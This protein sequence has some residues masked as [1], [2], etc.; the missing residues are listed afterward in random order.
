VFKIISMTAAAD[1]GIFGLNQ[2]YRCTGTWQQPDGFTRYDW[3]EGG[4]GTITL[5]QSLTYSCD[6]YNY[7]IGLELNQYD[8]EALGNYA[9]KLGLGELTGVEELD[10]A[11]GH[12]PD[13]D[14]V[15]NNTTREWTY[16]D[17]INMAVGQG[18]V[19][20]TPLQV[21]RMMAAVANGGTLY[22]P[23]MVHHIG[24]IG[25]APSWT[26]EPVAQRQ[27]DVKAE[28]LEAVQD[29]LCAVT[30]DP[31]GTATWRY[32]G[33]EIP[34]CGKTGTAETNT[35][36]VAWFAAYAPAD[37]P[38][39]AVVVM[40]EESHEGS[41]VSAPIVRRIIEEYYGVPVAPYPAD[42]GYAMPALPEHGGD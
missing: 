37:D 39:I 30:T 12:I 21:T 3:L 4:H 19:L 2:T 31:N 9:R 38:K 16:N 26:M 1:T 27:I 28:V 41:Y 29:A 11:D 17:N 7:Q 42:W 40:V 24:L 22:Q 10:E 8:P 18:D 20:V 23:Q 34:T 6:P 5:R 25:E 33:M 13:P 14:W 36:P 35:R 15:Q 32:E